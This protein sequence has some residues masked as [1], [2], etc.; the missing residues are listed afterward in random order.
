M[1]S[2]GKCETP[3]QKCGAN[4][5]VITYNP[6]TIENKYT[7]FIKSQ[8]QCQQ[9]TVCSNGACISSSVSTVS[10]PET[11][12]NVQESLPSISY[13]FDTSTK[14]F[15][16]K[17]ATTIPPVT[18]FAIYG[19][20]D[21]TQFRPGEPITISGVRQTTATAI[22]N[23]GMLVTITGSLVYVNN[24]RV[25]LIGSKTAPKSQYVVPL[26]KQLFP[27]NCGG[28]I[29]VTIA[30]SLVFDKEGL[31]KYEA[32]E[33][34]VSFQL[35]RKKTAKEVVSYEQLKENLIKLVN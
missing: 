33:Y 32:V 20:P 31:D 22:R 12:C 9:G 3:A 2:S 1:P 25:S 8:T 13:Q 26:K 16:S 18:Y 30:Q 19:K 10:G 28:N 11:A 23:P 6:G 4:N 14:S 21:K 29:P 17:K 34:D 24:K 35:A 15:V 27:E 7:P 5:V